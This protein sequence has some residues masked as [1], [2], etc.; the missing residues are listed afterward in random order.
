M[1]YFADWSSKHWK[2]TNFVYLLHVELMI[3]LV[4][5]RIYENSRR[6]TKR[7]TSSRNRE[8]KREKKNTG[9]ILYTLPSVAIRPPPPPPPLPP[10]P[11]APPSMPYSVDAYQKLHEKLKIIRMHR[12]G[13]SSASSVDEFIVLVIYEGHETNE[14]WNKCKRARNRG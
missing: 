8:S 1:T 7:L 10:L 5:R 9:M 4:I 11:S 12:L 2:K 3:L 6:R 14:S 13:R